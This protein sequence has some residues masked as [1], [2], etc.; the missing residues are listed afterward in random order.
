MLTLG[1]EGILCLAAGIAVVINADRIYR[2]NV[3]DYEARKATWLGRM[4]PWRAIAES[5]HTLWAIRFGGFVLVLMGLI[6]LV[7]LVF[8]R[9]PQ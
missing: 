9:A 8:G 6:L 1:L 7:G 5:R 3:A 4:M 2:A